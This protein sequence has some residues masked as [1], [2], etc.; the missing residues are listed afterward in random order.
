[1]LQIEYNYY[2]AHKE[3][4]NKKYP[5]KFLGIVGEKVVGA[6]LT[7]LEAYEDLKKKYGAGKFLIQESVS[8]SNH[9]QRYHSRVAFI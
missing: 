6:Y 4:L 7:E 5:G 9:I 1:M 2:K 8:D 3:E